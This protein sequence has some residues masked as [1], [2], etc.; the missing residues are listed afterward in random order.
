M[1]GHALCVIHTLRV[2]LEP[3]PGS[4]QQYRQQHTAMHCAASTRHCMPA[5]LLFETRMLL[6]LA[7]QTLQPLKHTAADCLN[8]QLAIAP[9]S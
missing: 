7:L 9:C 6:L 1:V 2:S 8:P 3:E 5:M 4:Q